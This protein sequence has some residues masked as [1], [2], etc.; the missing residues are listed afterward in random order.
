MLVITYN[1]RNLHL[2]D[3]TVTYCRKTTILCRRAQGSRPQSHRI[4]L[5]WIRLLLGA[6]GC[7]DPGGRMGLGRRGSGGRHM[8]LFSVGRGIG[9]GRMCWRFLRLR[10]ERWAERRGWKKG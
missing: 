8:L 3:A 7:R 10:R 5:F 4:I 9:T 6:W 2:H 1:P